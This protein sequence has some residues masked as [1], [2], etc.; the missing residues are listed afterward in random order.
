MKT[1]PKCHNNE[2]QVKNGFNRSGSQRWR[3]QAYGK[4]YTPQPNEIGYSDEMR[5]K[6]VAMYV[7]GGNFRRIARHLG[8]DH[9]TIIN[10]VKAHVAQLDAAPVPSDVNN[11]E[12][13]ELFTFVRS[14]KHRLPDDSG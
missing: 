14:K 7:D 8:V 2:K 13:D 5:R 12:T 9:K 1:C 6:A 11:A 4:R 3:C 10:W